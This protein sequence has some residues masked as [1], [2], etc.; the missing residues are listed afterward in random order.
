ML[1]WSQ[2]PLSHL[3]VTP[4]LEAMSLD[5]WVLSLTLPLVPVLLPSLCAS[6]FP[7]VKWE[8]STVFACSSVHQRQ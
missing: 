4:E 2:K 6:G 7:A 3:P 5:S 1:G 8:Y